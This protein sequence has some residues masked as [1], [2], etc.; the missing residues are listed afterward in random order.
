MS[1]LP[2]THHTLTTTPNEWPKTTFLE[3]HPL[4]T[5]HVSQLVTGDVTCHAHHG[6]VTDFRPILGNP[7]EVTHVTSLGHVYISHA[8]GTYFP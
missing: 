6:C 7:V 3:Q 5:L 4:T 2:P 1:S 8:K